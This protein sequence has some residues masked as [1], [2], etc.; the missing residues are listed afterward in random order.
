MPPCIKYK[1]LVKVFSKMGFSFLRQKGSH[2]RWGHHDGRRITIPN[3]KEIAYG[4][5]CSI[6]EQAGI[7]PRIFFDE[8]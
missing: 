6:C 8:M 3:H 7:S 4:T 1:V 5:F 2:E